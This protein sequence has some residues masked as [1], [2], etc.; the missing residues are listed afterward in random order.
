MNRKEVSPDGVAEGFQENQL[1]DST[2]HSL[3]AG[4]G[5]VDSRRRPPGPALLCW[6]GSF[7]VQPVA[8]L[9]NLRNY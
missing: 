1:D 9:R 6:L 4:P 8:F 3:P 2:R 5:D 7:K